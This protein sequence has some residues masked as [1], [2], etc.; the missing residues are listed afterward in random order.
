MASALGLTSDTC[1][2]HA[3]VPCQDL[4]Q[5]KLCDVKVSKAAAVASL[6][7]VSVMREGPLSGTVTGAVGRA[8]T[9]IRPLGNCLWGH[10]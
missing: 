8:D 7:T 2:H 6:A 3:S 9:S 10:S 1:L 4:K 5:V